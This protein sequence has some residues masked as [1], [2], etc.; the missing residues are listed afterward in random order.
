MV[1]ASTLETTGRLEPAEY[2]IATL[3]TSFSDAA[4][5]ERYCWASRYGTTSSGKVA[6]LAGVYGGDEQPDLALGRNEEVDAPGGV[7]LRAV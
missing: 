5:W 4:S 2:S 1:P 6:E 3:L 7:R